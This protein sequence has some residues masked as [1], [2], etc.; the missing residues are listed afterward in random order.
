MDDDVKFTT[1]M[2]FHNIRSVRGDYDEV[3][4]FSEEVTWR[5]KPNTRVGIHNDMSI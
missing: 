1:A 3:K 5:E 4:P 2:R